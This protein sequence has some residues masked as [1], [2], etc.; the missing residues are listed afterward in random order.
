M[1]CAQGPWFKAFCHLSLWNRHQRSSAGKAQGPRRQGR[2]EPLDDIGQLVVGVLPAH[3]SCAAQCPTHQQA[4]ISAEQ[5]AVLTSGLPHKI[6]IAS[7]SVVGRV[8]TEE[9]K[10]AGKRSEVH[11]QQEERWPLQGLRPSSDDDLEP[12][13]LLQP[14]S[15]GQRN[16]GH[17][18]VPYFSHRHTRT[19]DDMSYRGSGVVRQVELAVLACPPRQKEAQ[20]GVEA[21]PDHAARHRTRISH[22]SRLVHLRAAFQASGH[23]SIRSP[24]GSVRDNRDSRSSEAWRSSPQGVE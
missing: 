9:P 8:H 14:A 6:V 22:V 1:L 24:T 10:L 5:N 3:E 21:Q 2:P 11:V 4:P 12:V 17:D 16:L 13:H 15:T 7:V 19:L 20:A 23:G 18:Q